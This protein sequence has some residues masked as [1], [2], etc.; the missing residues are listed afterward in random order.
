M[1][2]Q[3]EDLSDY[4][5]HHGVKGMKW[6]VRNEETQRKYAGGSGLFRRSP[7]QNAK[8]NQEKA[9]KAKRA[10]TAQ[11]RRFLSDD[12]LQKHVQRLQNEKK[13]K[14]LTEQDLHP[15]RQQVKKY[16]GAT[17]G[18]AA[19]AAG[20]A[21]AKYIIGTSAKGEKPSLKDAGQ[22]IGKSLLKV[23]K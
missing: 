12:E 2:L 16:A 20:L 6:G 5:A 23:K 1:E 13:L 8:R 9:I 14:E 10:T 7:S 4:L 15:G 22:F 17:I 21:T 3:Y 18:V 19:T 11:N